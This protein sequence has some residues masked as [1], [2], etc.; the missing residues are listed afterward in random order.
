[1]SEWY[2]DRENLRQVAQ[3]IVDEGCEAED[4]VHLIE[5][6]WKYNAE[7]LHLAG[8]PHSARDCALAHSEEALDG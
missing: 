5:K 1:M 7:W 6:P 8:Q 3:A 4:V 2:D